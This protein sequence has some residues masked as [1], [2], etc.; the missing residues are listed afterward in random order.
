MTAEGGER[1]RTAL[2]IAKLLFVSDISNGSGSN[3]PEIMDA[4]ERAAKLLLANGIGDVTLV[5]S[6]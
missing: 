5:Y 4:C 1:D 3:A 2:R 6:P